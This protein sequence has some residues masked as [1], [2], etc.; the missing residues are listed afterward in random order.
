MYAMTIAGL[1]DV[2]RGGTNGRHNDTRQFD[3][4]PASNPRSATNHEDNRQL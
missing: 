1:T 2:L 3:C 4:S